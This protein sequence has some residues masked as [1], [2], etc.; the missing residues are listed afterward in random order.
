MQRSFWVKCGLACSSAILLVVTLAWH[1][2]IELV[3]GVDPDHGSGALEWLIVA[4]T[5]V[6]TFWF[7]ASA[8]TEWR[9]HARSHA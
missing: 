7:A 3:F 6:S 8:R 5:A 4:L 1:D 2:W 9:S